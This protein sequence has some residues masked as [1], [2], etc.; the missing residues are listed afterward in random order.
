ML[1]RLTVSASTYFTLIVL[2]SVLK[3][4]EKQIVIYEEAVSHT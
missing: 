1:D 4:S 3:S 2:D